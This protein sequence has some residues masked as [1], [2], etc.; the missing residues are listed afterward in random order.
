MNIFC[1]NKGCMSGVVP[2]VITERIFGIVRRNDPNRST[3]RLLI[4]T[5]VEMPRGCE[6]R[7]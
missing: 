1:K 3:H 4:D 7:T 6:T 5:V 2:V